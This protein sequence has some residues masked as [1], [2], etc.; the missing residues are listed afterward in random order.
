MTDRRQRV[1]LQDLLGED[2][3][4]L[5]NLVSPDLGDTRHC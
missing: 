4:Y 1:L 2:S 5:Y 3:A